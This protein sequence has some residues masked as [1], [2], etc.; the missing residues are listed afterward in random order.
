MKDAPLD[1]VIKKEDQEGKSL[2]GVKLAVY[3][4]KKLPEN[5]DHSNPYAETDKVAEWVTDESG[6]FKLPADANLVV[7]ETYVLHELET[8]KGYYYSK[9]VEFTVENT[10][11]EQVVTMTNRKIIVE[12]PPDENLYR[13]PRSRQTRATP[14][15]R[16]CILDS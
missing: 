10:G 14:W 8:I 12:V 16:A 15:K 9:D 11:K 1:I 13:R 5:A 4:G 2:A 3:K 7:G 6:S